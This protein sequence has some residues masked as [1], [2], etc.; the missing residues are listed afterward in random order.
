MNLKYALF[1]F[2]EASH[3]FWLI[4]GN[5]LYYS[6]GNKCGE[7]TS[8]LSLVMYSFL[9]IGYLHFML[10]GVIFL[11]VL[12]LLVKRRRQRAQKVRNSEVVMK[13]LKK[14]R[15]KYEKIRALGSDTEANP[16]ASSDEASMGDNSCIICWT[17]YEATDEV[18]RLDCNSKHFF[19]AACVESWVNS[20][21]NTC[22]MC[23]QAIDPS[24]PQAQ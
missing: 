3:L 14:K 17:P 18:I 15:V 5:Y 1:T 19:H 8:F 22:P 7:E 6:Q 21:N 16:R 4:Y 10:Y 9:L 12:T 11:I 13:K 24:V 20:G 23:R 2:V